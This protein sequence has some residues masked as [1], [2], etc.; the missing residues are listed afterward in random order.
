MQE[1]SK[2]KSELLAEIVILKQRIQKLEKLEARR[3][4]AGKELHETES[5]YKRLFVNASEGI[6]VAEL[7]TKQFIYANPALCRM[8][9]YTEG[10]MLQ[11][12]VE[13]IHP[14]AS[15]KHVLAEF[16]ALA[17]GKKTRAIN[18]PCLRRDGSVF[19]A[20]IS[21]T[22]LVLDDV[23]CNVGFFIDNTEH[24]QAEEALQKSD[25]ELKAL[26]KSM[27]N[28][29]VLF[30]SVFD[31][32]G[33]FVS[34][35]FVY[36]NDAYERI[37]GV[38]NDDVRGKTVHEVWPNTEASWVK[39]YGD[40]ATTGVQSSF[41]MYHESTGKLYHCNVYRPWDTKDRF[42]VVFEDITERKKAEEA[43]K[44]SEEKYRSL[45]ENANEAIFVALDGKL[46]FVNPMTVIT[47]G[48]SGEE[49]VSR[50]FTAFIHQ[51]DRDMVIDRHVR[52]MKG[53]ETPNFY[54]FRII[55]GEGN[56][57]WVE[58]NSVLINWLGK[59]A[60]LNFVSDI[61]DR[62]K[63]EEALR[64]SESKFR[65][66]FESA[67]DA[68]FLMDQDIFVDCNPKA[69]EMF[70]CTKEQVIGQ[71][72]F[73]FSPEVQPD[74]RNSMEKALEKINAA[75]KGHPQFFEWKHSRYD[76]TLFDSE[77]N[78]NA[79]TDSGKSYLQSIVRD[80]TVRKRVEEALQKSEANYRQLFD[81]SPTAIYQFD[82]RTGKFLKANDVL[83]ELLGC[84]QEKITSFS[85][86]NM[87]SPESQ[88][89]LLERLAKIKSGEKVT[90][91]P[92]YEV[93][94]KDGKKRWVHLNSKNIYDSEGS[95]I[96]ADVVAHEITDRKQAEEA[97]RESE[98][99]YRFLTEKMTDI[100]WMA[101]MNLK[102][103]YVTPS[104]QTVLGFTQKERMHQTI[105][106]QLT[107]DSLSYGLE[108]MARELAL[109]EQG[110]GDPQRNATLVLE[111]YHKDG[112]TRWME[113]IISGIRNDRGVLT[114]LHGVSRD[115][116]E[117]K[118]AEVK[119]RRL[120]ERL[121][122][123]EKMEA[124]GQLAGGVA[125]D[126]NNVLGVL[127]GY[128]EL[129]LME[130]PEGQKTRKHVEKI[131]Q[132]TQKGAAII[133]DLL[134]LARRGVNTSEVVNFNNVV[135][136]FLTTPVFENIKDYHPRVTFRTECDKNLLNIKGSLVHLEKTL[137]N[138][139]SNAAEA[140]TETGDVTIRTENRY[141]D[142]AIVGYD[143][144]NEGDYAVL[145]VSDTGM[146][147]PAE[148]RKKIFDP[149]YTKKTMGRSGTGLG[150]S[151]V[152]GTVKDHNGYID[153]QTKVGEGTTFTLYFPVTREEMT[154]PQQK[155]SIERYMGRG[156]S[157]LVVDDIAEQRDVA[158]GLLKKL[159][160]EVHTA[161]S[162]EAAVE[163]FKKNKADILLLD[164][165]MAP[166]I[167]GLEA[168]RRILEIN[169]QQKTILVSGFSE[170]DRVWM[171]QRLGA[172]TY[173]KKPYVM[174]TIGLAIRDELKR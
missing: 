3:K 106:Q 79:F 82:F 8:F 98:N 159:G 133:Q 93:I 22:S 166:G 150:L 161:S 55:N 104:I 5:S 11:L 143:E 69:L 154:A 134:T 39:A 113:T 30:E 138:L 67:N 97:L 139:V 65:I 16:D 18:I 4:R 80:I 118:Q 107:P 53:E 145:S 44:D 94:D 135:S 121:H 31:Q 109:E 151:I 128:S 46:V 99:K 10:E 167:D 54:A 114:G 165:I 84:S 91:N 130:I 110:E 1:P 172:G 112:S 74:G 116:T 28:A 49:L 21:N 169:P 73:R 66:L 36:I 12:S 23:K 77:V 153:V 14:K 86:L 32:D 63:A 62:K 140:I 60:T 95:V 127:S 126:L 61:T 92:E 20:N 59:P 33:N 123:A 170:T 87:M 85:P 162:G 141:L 81:N 42:C 102:T 129:L 157:I 160:Y 174:E 137:M 163:Y 72:P 142:K 101:D 76:E 125:H 132:S 148:S 158:S 40:V 147:I 68:I 48:Y 83:C 89:L 164:M 122:R 96:G 38:K 19:Y 7:Q 111:Y 120:E 50:P 34:Y 103:L 131:L 70:G 43:L 115:I 171:A 26:F 2:T 136:G 156:E 15:M 75:L 24:Q 173:V 27:L 149:F 105:D 124:L 45:I 78:L 51:D 71:R 25:R 155:E 13:D 144:V 146:G 100:V 117:S 29:F 168:Y 90:E 35:R 57:R 58:L 47:M 37:T 119:N 6:L 41:D 64:E 56:I 152:W 108:A 88:K 52:R 9:G 17:R